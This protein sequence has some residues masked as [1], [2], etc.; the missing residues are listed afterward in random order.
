[1]ID[2][3]KF[4]KSEARAIQGA[5]QAVTDATMEGGDVAAAQASLASLVAKAEKNV[6]K[7]RKARVGRAIMR[8]T[9]IGLGLTPVRGAVSGK[10]YWE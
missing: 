5:E 7:R 8:D 9:Y 6:G 4:T 1:M 3:S 2:T 10:L